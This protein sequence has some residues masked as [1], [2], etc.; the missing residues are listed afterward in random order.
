MRRN[1][2][3]RIQYNSPVVLTF[4][5]ISFAALFLGQLTQGWTDQYLFC[6]YRSS[7]LDPLTYIRLFGHVLGHANLAHLTGNMMLFL[8]LGPIL[9]EKYGSR[10]LLQ[11]FVLVAVVTGVVNMIFF[12]GTALM[13]ASGIVFMMIILAS[14]TSV[15]RRQIPLTLIIV[16]VLYLGQEVYDGLFVMDNISHLS[17]IVGGVCGCAFGFTRK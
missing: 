4:A 16:A 7:L 1:I 8:L 15:G 5:L 11:M 13:G 3:W 9:E 12:P 14:M 6:V 10:A 17:H 2:F